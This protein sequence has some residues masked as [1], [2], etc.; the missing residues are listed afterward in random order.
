[1]TY[2]GDVQAMN[3]CVTGDA[4][5][6]VRDELVSLLARFTGT[7]PEVVL[8]TADLAQHD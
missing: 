8:V 5:Y 1:M 7:E 4:S 3:L 2:C 6:N